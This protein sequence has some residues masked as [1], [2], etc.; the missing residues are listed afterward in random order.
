M[1]RDRGYG[2]A[3]EGTQK[4]LHAAIVREAAVYLD[5]TSLQSNQLCDEFTRVMSLAPLA[6]AFLH[7]LALGGTLQRHPQDRHIGGVVGPD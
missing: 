1:R 3:D 2:N 7:R 5:P 4:A 6:P